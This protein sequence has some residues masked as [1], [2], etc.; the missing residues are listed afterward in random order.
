VS[1]PSSPG[2]SAISCSNPDVAAV[3]S[4][5]GRDGA[6]RLAFESR[7]GR[8]VLRERRFTL[9][10]QALEPMDLE[11]DGVAT[12]LL[13]NPTGGIL[14][15]DRLDTDIS[16]GPD[17]R[18]CLSTPSATRVYRS[19]GPPAVQRIT[20]GV[21]RGA[22][23]EWMPDHLIPS[24]GARLRQTTEIVLAPDATLLHLDAW[25][26]GR[27]AREEAWGF[28]L[29]DTSLLVRDEVG[30]LLRERCM[31]SGGA[32]WEGLGGTEGFGYVATFAAIRGG[33][34]GKWGGDGQAWDDLARA[35]QDDLDS[36]GPECRAGVTRL[37]RGG[38]LA[39]VLCPGA[40][41]LQVCVEALWARCRRELLGLGPLRLRKL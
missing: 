8:T 10:L 33:G 17:S 2:S 5:V 26:T 11:G 41:A 22:T 39:R 30:P 15:G 19:P 7:D 29:L 1:T 37:G 6:L 18:V 35:L 4:R 40:P 24:P 25:A 31:L 27:L 12:L 16:L 23:L 21:A 34:T 28:D 20:I 14:A 3:P 32:G 36:A 9:P 13:L 38:V